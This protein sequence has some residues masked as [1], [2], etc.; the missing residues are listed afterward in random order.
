MRRRAFLAVGTAGAGLAGQPA[1][2]FRGRAE[3][4]LC[5][6]W[7]FRTDRTNPWRKVTVPHT[8][9]IEQGLE[10][11]YGVAWYRRDFRLPRGWMGATVRIEFEAVFHSAQISVNGKPVGE[12]VRKGYTAFTLDITAADLRFGGVNRLEVKV[13]NSFNDQMLPRGRSSDWAHDGGIYRPVRLLASSSTYLERVDVDAGPEAIHV[14]AVV[15]G[16]ASQL[17]MSVVDDATGE[18]VFERGHPVKPGNNTLA[19]FAITNPNLWHFDRPHLYRLECRLASGHTYST[20]FGIRTFEARP[21]G[22]YLN[23]ERVFLTGV[24]RMAG[25]HPEYGMAEPAAWIEHDHADMK[26][27]NCIYTRV[28][29]PQDRRVLDYCDRHGILIQTE[30]PTW[31]PKTFEGMLNEPSPAIMNNGL[32]QLREMVARDRN[33]PSIVS[34]GLCNEIGGQNPPAYAFAKR[35]YQEAKQLDPNRLRSY[36][37]HSLFHTPEKDVAG[38]MDFVE[39]NEYFG[40]WQKGGANDLREKL[41]NIHRA[42]PNKLVVISE[43]G[44]CA[45]TADRP[46]GDAERIEVLLGHNR[47]FREAPYVAGLIFF[48]YNDYRTHIGDRGAGA[49]KQRIHGVVDL[50]GNRK[51]SWQY[52][53][54]EACPIQ[55][56][57]HTVSGD[58]WSVTLHSRGDLPAYTLRGYGLRAVGWG[59]SSIPYVRHVTPVPDLHPGE[60]VTVEFG[61]PA[62]GIEK[63]TLELVRPTGCTTWTS[64][65]SR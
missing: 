25:S 33:H 55:T 49:M 28:H 46:E 63:V 22:F 7:E 1:E 41:A 50:Y 52:L 32:E 34:W 14:N 30:V 45:C 31:G 18:V 51:P 54:Q 8:W 17:Q 5:G 56:A 15:R 11:H 26:E 44:Y 10:E 3:I 57:E 62:D 24:E 40:S 36:A 16:G 19:S 20:T 43:Y 59:P 12:H 13:D 37:S 64:T 21:D 60:K 61:L 35:M 53:R 9:Q 42:F 65:I 39:W 47:V 4:S 2:V 27:L 48:C 23:G 58:R 38:L 6:T 29:W